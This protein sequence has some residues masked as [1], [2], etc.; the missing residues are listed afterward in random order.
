MVH[1]I[2][3]MDAFKLPMKA[4][5]ALLDNAL[6]QFSQQRQRFFDK[7]IEEKNEIIAGL[8]QKIA[9]SKS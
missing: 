5:K 6:E 8:H 9:Q 2:H 3:H 1:P 4:R 7:E